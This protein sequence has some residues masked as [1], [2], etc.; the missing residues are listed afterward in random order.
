MCIPGSPSHV[1]L[2]HR[3]CGNLLQITFCIDLTHILSSFKL[4]CIFSKLKVYR[5]SAITNAYFV[6]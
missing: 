1:C 2:K 3:G 4:P 6:P 5:C